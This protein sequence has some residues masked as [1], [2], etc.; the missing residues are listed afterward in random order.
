MTQSAHDTS[1]QHTCVCVCV[2]VSVSACVRI[3]ARA[4]YMRV[5]VRARARPQHF[6]QRLPSLDTT[7]YPDKFQFFPVTANL[8]GGEG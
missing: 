4:I 5:C 7:Y 3:C 2:C 8:F 6:P 1:I